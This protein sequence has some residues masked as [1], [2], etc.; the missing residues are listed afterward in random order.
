MSAVSETPQKVTFRRF[1][2]GENKVRRLN[3]KIFQAGWSYKCPTYVQSTPP[4]QGSC[5]AGE[6]IRGYL[7]IVR[8]MEKPPKGTSMQE[9]AFRIGRTHSRE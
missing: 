6:D 7:N 3:D 1:K 2:D 9:Y 5:P 8:G 4:C